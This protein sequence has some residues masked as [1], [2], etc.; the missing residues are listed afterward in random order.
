MRA[1]F[2][3]QIA[4]YRLLVVVM[5]VELPHHNFVIQPYAAPLAS[6]TFY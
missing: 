4:D 5:S 3:L 2:R 1:R 6:A